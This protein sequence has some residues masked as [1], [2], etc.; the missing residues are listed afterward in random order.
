MNGEKIMDFKK[1]LSKTS[2]MIYSA[3]AAMLIVVATIS[4]GITIVTPGKAGV[5]VTLGKVNNGTLQEG[6][7]IV[8]PWMDDVHLMDVTVQKISVNAD[9]TSKDMQ[10]VRSTVTLNY[11]VDASKANFVYQNFKGQH[12]KIFILPAI[13]ESIKASTALF[14]AE[15]L[16]GQRQKVKET[17]TSEMTSRLKKEHLTVVAV[18]IENFE[19]SRV[20]NEAIEA[21]QVAA[22]KAL[23][24]RNYL[25]TI[26]IQAEQQKAKAEGEAS[27]IRARARAE[28]EANELIEKTL[29]DNVLRSRLIE[30]WNGNVPLV[31]GESQ[32][33]FLDII[34]AKKIQAARSK[35]KNKMTKQSSP[36][37]TR[38]KKK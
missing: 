35:T 5:V 12:Q 36:E 18:S 37:M 7:N 11:R 4:Q 28:A 24:E 9:A 38:P 6:V 34:D 10:E 3:V 30:K 31:V 32:S 23:E 26:K 25:E 29:T 21:K 15:Q 16:I 8:K 13:Q 1:H 2:I 20:F 19:F 33:S 22:Q 14:T 17:I 27:A